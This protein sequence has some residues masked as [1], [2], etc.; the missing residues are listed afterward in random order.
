MPR[1]FLQVANR[2]GISR[3][4]EAIAEADKGTAGDC[5]V[6][7]FRPR[8]CNDHYRLFEL[9]RARIVA[10]RVHQGPVESG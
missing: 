5:H 10:Q 8:S 4:T 7:K 1:R 6:E 3:L 2:D 9:N